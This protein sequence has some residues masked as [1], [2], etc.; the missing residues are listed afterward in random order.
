MILDANEPMRTIASA[1]TGSSRYW[2]R[3][4][5]GTARHLQVTTPYRGRVRAEIEGGAGG[6]TAT[7][8]VKLADAG[9]SPAD[10]LLAG[11]ASALGSAG[12]SGEGRFRVR[13]RRARSGRVLPVGHRQ[14]APPLPGRKAHARAAFPWPSRGHLLPS[15]GD[16]LAWL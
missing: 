6:E 1:Q 16:A 15:R 5:R 13:L 14:P 2:F 8:R 11:L 3:S 4:P 7:A 9:K 12:R 10:E